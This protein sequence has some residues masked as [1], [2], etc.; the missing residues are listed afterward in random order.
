MILKTGVTPLDSDEPVMYEIL[1]RSSPWFNLVERTR[2]FVLGDRFDED[3]DGIGR[4]IE[5]FEMRHFEQR[6]ALAE[7]A[8]DFINQFFENEYFMRTRHRAPFV[9]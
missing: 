7:R 4:S 6:H 8:D 5:V 1:R 3:T 2:N 9:Q